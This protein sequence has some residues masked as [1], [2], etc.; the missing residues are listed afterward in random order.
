MA[1]PIRIARIAELPPGKGKVVEVAGRRLTV[2]NQAGCFFASSSGRTHP[3]EP[4]AETS[5]DCTHHG[6]VFDVYAED[7]PATL[8]ADE[9]RC[10]V[11]VDEHYVWLVLAE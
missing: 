2:Y 10:T 9:L 1:T 3:S 6:L 5:T 11:W 4:I 8:R 7:S